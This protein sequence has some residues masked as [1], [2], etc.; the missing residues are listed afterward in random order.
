M[1]NLEAITLYVDTV[2]INE[3]RYLQG[4]KAAADEALSALL[5][6]S[7]LEKCKDLALRALNAGAHGSGLTP[8]AADGAT[9]CEHGKDHCQCDNPRCPNYCD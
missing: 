4:Y 1:A 9:L 5:N 6:G 8:R 7:D 2:L 3:I